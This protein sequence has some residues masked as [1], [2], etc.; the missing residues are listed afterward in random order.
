M[1][2]FWVV[3][4]RGLVGSCKRLGEHIASIFRAEYGILVKLRNILLSLGIIFLEAKPQIRSYQTP[5]TLK[6]ILFAF[7]ALL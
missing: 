3:A 4:A 5:Y 7:N 1:L 6:L 2:L